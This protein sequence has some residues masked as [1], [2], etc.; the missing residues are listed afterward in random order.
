MFDFPEEAYFP[1]GE[2]LETIVDW[3]RDN[4]EPLFDTVTVAI[5]EPL[6]AIERFLLWLPWWAVILVFAAVA[7]RIAGRRIAA[8]AAIGMFVIGSLGGKI[9]LWDATMTTLAVIVTAI[10]VSLFIGIP[11]G[12]LAAK[13]DRFRAVIR[14]VLDLMQ[15]MPSFVYLI[16]AV[17]LF[18]LGKVPAVIATFIYAVP[19]CIRLTDLG[20][21]QVSPEVV[22]AG[23]AFGSTQWQL[24][25]KIQ[26]PL[27]M[28]SIMA[29]VNQTIMLALAMVVIASM[30]GAAG[31]GLEVLRAIQR[32][33]L[34]LGFS[35]GLCIVILAVILDRIT[36]AMAGA[37]AA[38]EGAGG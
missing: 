13:S 25:F 31:L 11:L 8:L 29:G 26:L 37:R 20:I 1:L 17:F 27:A 9:N 30:I 36:Q 16:P 19:P 33:D 38:R 6:V 18:G 35:A 4:L 3:L 2:W 15:T 10:V 7:W 23:K 5:R 21:R 34:A 28:P 12:I 14:P 22:E 32:L 24:L